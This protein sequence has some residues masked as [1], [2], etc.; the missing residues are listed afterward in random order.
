MI[1]V[2]LWPIMLILRSDKNQ[3]PVHFTIEYSAILL[4]RHDIYT[5]NNFAVNKLNVNTVMCKK[6][7]YKT[8]FK[9]INRKHANYLISY[10]FW[11][12]ILGGC[13]S[14][15]QQIHPCGCKMYLT[16]FDLIN[17]FRQNGF[18]LSFRLRDNKNSF[19][20]YRRQ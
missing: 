20:I 9:Y 3:K 1:S 6:E 18:R 4:S 7:N 2:Q 12:H 11:Y 15:V 14:M 17:F 13:A 16:F 8:A 10:F 5:D 19:G